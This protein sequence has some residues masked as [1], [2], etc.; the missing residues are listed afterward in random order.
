MNEAVVKFL[1]KG[2]DNHWYL[3]LTNVI[4]HQRQREAVLSLDNDHNY[5]RMLQV[6]EELVADIDDSDNT[7]SSVLTSYIGINVQLVLGAVLN[8]HWGVTFYSVLGYSRNKILKWDHPRTIP[9]KFGLIRFK[10]FRE[11]D[12][13]VIF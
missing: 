12:L 11:E 13:N 10:G 7:E 5:T 4:P 3:N 6:P 1:R 2:Q 8:L 9:T